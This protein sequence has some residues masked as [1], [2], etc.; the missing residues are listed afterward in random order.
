MIF[1]KQKRE[2]KN[3]KR[4]TPLFLTRGV[5]GTHDLKLII[6]TINQLKKKILKQYLFQGLINLLMID[7]KKNKWQKIKKTTSYNYFRG[8]V[9]GSKT[10]KK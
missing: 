6:K 7:F 4:V 3:V 9:C 5:P 2:K 8:M 1:I 10:S